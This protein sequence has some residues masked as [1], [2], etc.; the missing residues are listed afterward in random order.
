[1]VQ[2]GL[3]HIGFFK[4]LFLQKRYLGLFF[5][6]AAMKRDQEENIHQKGRGQEKISYRILGGVNKKS[7]QGHKKGE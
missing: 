2:F 3:E 6:Q 5:L 4:I 1:M 7:R